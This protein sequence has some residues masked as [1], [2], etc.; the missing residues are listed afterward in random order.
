MNKV[1]YRDLVKEDYESI[2]KLIGEA[3]GFNKIIK[4]KKFLD[5]VLN[6]YLQSCIL[7]SSFSKVAE[8]NNKII[9]VILGDSTKDKNRLRKA[10]NT[11]SYAYNMLKMF[12]ANK[13]DK[14]FMKEFV[15]VQDAYKE[16][17]YGKEDDFQGCIQLFIVSGESR[18]LGVGKTL[19]NHLFNY[20]ESM[21]VKS[22]YLYTDAKCNYGFYDNQN[23]ERINEKEIYFDSMKAKLN[24]FLYC[25]DF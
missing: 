8:R 15:K 2:K 14:Q 4:D 1:I 20:M 22:L 25:Y 21:D 24:V 16:L 11:F 10:H 5:S 23:F 19:M 6:I 12:I 7:G 13:E 18:G 9:G 17:I 3:F